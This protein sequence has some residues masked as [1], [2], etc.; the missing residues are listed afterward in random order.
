MSLPVI[1]LL[2][3][4]LQGFA[5]S[6]CAWLLLRLISRDA[7]HRAWTAA[8]GLLACTL[9]PLLL[10]LLPQPITIS[11][12]SPASNVSR[13]SPLGD[14]R[15]RLD[16]DPAPTTPASV[17][18][19]P[20]R[21][22]RFIHWQHLLAGAWLT[23]SALLILAGGL[24]LHRSLRWRRS[25]R[26]LT[27]S[28][29]QSLPPNLP[30][31]DFLVSDQPISPC[32]AGL[33]RPVM[34]VPAT[35]ITCWT[36]ERWH[37]MLAHETEHYRGRDHLISPLIALSKILWWWNPFTRSLASHWSL[38]REE[39]C[40][41]AALRPA[42]HSADPS[43]YARFLL[44]LA[45]SQPPVPLTS[46][47]MATSRPARRLKQRITALLEH[48]PVAPRLH[49]V[50]PLLTL[51]TLALA[52]LGVRS[53]GVDAAPIQKEAPQAKAPSE[54]VNNPKQVYIS[55]K[56]VELPVSVENQIP[57]IGNLNSLE[58]VL[59]DPQLVEVIRALSQAKDI[60]LLAAPGVS[61]K[62][63]QR[64]TVEVLR[65]VQ[66]ETSSNTDF[67]GFRSDLTAA[68]KEDG[69]QIEV[70][71]S[72]DMGVAF[73]DGKR[74]LDWY[75]KNPAT[76]NTTHLRA[77]Q[78]IVL[79]DGNTL[80][81][82]IG[83]PEPDRKVFLFVTAS[84]IGPIGDEPTPDQLHQWVSAKSNS[85][86]QPPATATPKKRV[87]LAAKIIEE[88]GA[89]ALKAFF[90]V[91]QPEASPSSSG[92][93]AITPAA[94]VL[95]PGTLALGGVLN[96]EQFAT[97]TTAL[98][99]N[100]QVQMTDIPVA[101]VNNIEATLARLND[102]QILQV[103][104]ILGAEGQTI[105][106]YLRFLQQSEQPVNASLVTIWSG[107][108]VMFSEIIAVDESGK[109]THSRAICITA[110]IDESEENQ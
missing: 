3:F 106:L 69:Y 87:R 86:P 74:V 103:N 39:V 30:Q 73:Q 46:L 77:S 36:P 19:A 107:Q 12:P 45:A 68:I 8:L 99:R 90:P 34:V 28:E 110:E 14:W 53:L 57:F 2:H 61:V 109:P 38:A 41:A 100:N 62:S 97:L 104:P 79:D 1:S 7:R 55:T 26:P 108:T 89:E 83:H 82:P 13:L 56:W 29:R 22:P 40:D 95:P 65:E 35:A 42:A 80:L 23:G 9:L 98:K 47:A 59:T 48:R 37:W 33:F 105:D 58:T 15:I 63:G 44:E 78:T 75:A 31:T 60:D 66:N 88:K 93:P 25:L 81:L 64:A 67:V 17:P 10:L 16:A 96:P 18:A 27:A 49:P 54:I 21:L 85:P 6:A 52:S 91:P 72:A 4:G 94:A 102:E 24:R 43:D 50:Y 76:L 32:L 101:Q 84:L 71:I 5:L 20:L 51:F 92:E 11:S 70:S